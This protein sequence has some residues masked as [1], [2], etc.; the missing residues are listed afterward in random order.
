MEMEN[1]MADAT[2]RISENRKRYGAMRSFYKRAAIQA[3][4][5]L[6]MEISEYHI[7]MI[8][9]ALAESKIALRRVDDETYAELSALF[10]LAG[11]FSHLK[12]DNF[13]DTMMTDVEEDIKDLAR[14]FA[15]DDKK[16]SD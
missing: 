14:K 10:A 12:A 8:Q 4:Q 1:F 15:P 6:G 2:N 5:K 9:I 7:V 16:R 13:H 3:S 11:D